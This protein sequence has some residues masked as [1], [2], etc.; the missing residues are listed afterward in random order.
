MQA[1]SKREEMTTLLPKQCL[2]FWGVD[3]SHSSFEDLQ[4]VESFSSPTAAII[5]CC[6]NYLVALFVVIRE[7]PAFAND[8][9]RTM[10]ADESSQPFRS[11]DK[12]QCF[13]FKEPVWAWKWGSGFIIS[14]HATCEDGYAGVDYML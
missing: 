1:S 13:F 10:W 2:L 14:F 9:P 11:L 7:H 5:V 4:T 12:N 8:W 3:V 6:C